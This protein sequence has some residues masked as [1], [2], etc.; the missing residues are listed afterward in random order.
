MRR[1][2]DFCGIIAH[3]KTHKITL[4]IVFR[5]RVIIPESSKTPQTNIMGYRGIVAHKNT[6]ERLSIIN[7]V[8]MPLS[9]KLLRRLIA[10]ETEWEETGL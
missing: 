10:K 7:A 3:K 8:I 1:R 6:K 5:K 2:I 4:S 9:G